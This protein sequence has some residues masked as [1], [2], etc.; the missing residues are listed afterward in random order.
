MKFSSNLFSPVV[1][2]R[3]PYTLSRVVD[4]LHCIR[5]MKLRT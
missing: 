5:M 3:N 1:L 4:L 2:A